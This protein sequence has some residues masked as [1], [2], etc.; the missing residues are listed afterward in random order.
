MLENFNIQFGFEHGDY[1]YEVAY[2]DDNYLLLLVSIYSSEVHEN[3]IR[4]F[5]KFKIYL[6]RLVGFAIICCCLDLQ[7]LKLRKNVTY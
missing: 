6:H 1:D 7:S 2:N 3:F 5:K 4:N